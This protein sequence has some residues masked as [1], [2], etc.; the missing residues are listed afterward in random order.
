M[1]R[2]YVEISS[3]VNTMIEYNVNVM[4]I[5]MVV[6]ID[7]DLNWIVGISC[8]STMS[9]AYIHR[10]PFS[11]YPDVGRILKSVWY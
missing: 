9:M 4:I 7:I 8:T 5:I 3:L 10:A 11:N 1:S 2:H 6:K